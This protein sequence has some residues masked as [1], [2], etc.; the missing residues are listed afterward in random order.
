MLEIRPDEFLSF[1]EWFGPAL[2]G[3]IVTVPILIAVAVFACYL[4]A[5]ARRG[6]VEGFYSVAGVIASAIGRDL[7]ATSPRRILAMTRLTIKEAIRRRVLIGFVIF[8]LVFLFAGWFLDVKSTNPARLYLSFVLTTTNYLVIG[9][10]LFMATVSLPSDIKSRTMYTIMTKPVRA[11]EIVLGRVLGFVAVISVLLVV[12]GLVSYFFV[13]RGLDHEHAVEVADGVPLET[14][15]APLVPGESSP[16]WEGETTYE[17]HH[18][19]TWTVDT[20]GRGTTDE[21]MQHRHRVVRSDEG[22]EVR[23]TLGPPNGA[24]Q[25]RV[26]IYGELRFLDRDGSP[27]KGISVGKEWEYRSYIEGRTLATAI[28]R[29]QNVTEPMVDGDHIPIAMTLGVFRTYKADIEKGVRGVVIVTSTNPRNPLQCEP[30]GFESKEYDTLQ[31]PI[32]RT[33]RAIGADGTVGEEVDIIDDLVHNGELEF[34][35]RCDDPVQ[36]FGMAQADLYIEAPPAS[37][38]WNF[39][40]A[41]VG[42]W[43]QMVIVVCLGVMF[44][45]FLSSPVA[46][47]ATMSSVVLGFFNFFVSDM[48]SGKAFGGGPIEALIRLVTQSNLTSPL[49]LSG[50]NVTVGLIQ[51]VDKMLLA[52]MQ[53]AASVLP[54]FG[55]LGRAAEYVAY[56]FN[57]YDQ[58]LARQCL[59]TLIYVTAITIVGYFFLKTREIAA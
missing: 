14:E 35:I 34:W 28:W 22:G 4:V 30:I 54:D 31:L 12:M 1:S 26:P 32:P 7:P 23:Y 46:I 43:L 21:V 25:A 49:E 58:L 6:P 41:Y 11:G 42:I 10:A 33:L 19:H 3:F 15:I 20:E 45:T 59:A 5:A 51:F 44:S 39:T 29:F 2:Q 24:M 27:G 53:A 40:K 57:Y 9:L 37:V 38:P 48:W 17:A 56:N 18:Q 50:G 13:T 8:V 16:G 47:L 52:V 55:G 36:Y